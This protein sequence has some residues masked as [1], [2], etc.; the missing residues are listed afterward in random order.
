M[1]SMLGRSFYCIPTLFSY[2]KIPPIHS[3]TLLNQSLTET[4][5][6]RPGKLYRRA[7]PMAPFYQAEKIRARIHS[8]FAYEDR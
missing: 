7:R 8:S 6:Y 2:H 5:Y 1:Y 4:F 3:L